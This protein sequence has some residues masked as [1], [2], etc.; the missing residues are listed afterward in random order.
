MGGSRPEKGTGKRE[1]EKGKGTNWDRRCGHGHLIAVECE[2][3]ETNTR[4]T[5]RDEMRHDVVHVDTAT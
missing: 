2:T 4:I 5:R 3:N 1:R